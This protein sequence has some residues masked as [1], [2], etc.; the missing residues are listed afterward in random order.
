MTLIAIAASLAIAA[1]GAL[2]LIDPD[3]L[4]AT[5][6][7]FQRPGGL[8]VAAGI[9]LIL[10]AALY[11]AAD[12]SR[13]PETLRVWGIVVVL[14]GLATPV[15][16]RERFARLLDWWAGLGPGFVRSWAAFALLFGLALVFALVD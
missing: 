16:G 2:G 8:Y 10:G 14:A 12:D 5:V 7:S 6:R 3:R 13:A 9:R 11:L 4:L 1:L 15:F